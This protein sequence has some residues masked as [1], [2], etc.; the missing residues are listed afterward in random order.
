MHVRVKVR[1]T[2]VDSLVILVLVSLLTRG[3]SRS[4]SNFQHSK[5]AVEKIELKNVFC[6][7]IALAIV[8]ARMQNVDVR[9][10]DG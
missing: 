6:Q 10:V 4:F 7:Q 5:I 2:V 8:N 1:R 3:T 9:L